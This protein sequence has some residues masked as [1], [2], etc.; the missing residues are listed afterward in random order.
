MCL[1]ELIKQWSC[2]VPSEASGSP[3]TPQSAPYCSA[4][5]PSLSLGVLSRHKPED[6]RLT[7]EAD[8]TRP[9][10]STPPQICVYS[11]CSPASRL[12][13]DPLPQADVSPE[14]SAK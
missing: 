3:P 8:R 14:H 1:D 13:R 2:R 7:V 4:A 6:P 9:G 12:P 10:D 11:H 5:E